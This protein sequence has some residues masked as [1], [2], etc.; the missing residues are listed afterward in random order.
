V[1]VKVL[2]LELRKGVD[3][4]R[5]T[6]HRLS[7]RISR[8]KAV[9]TAEERRIWEL[10]RI[11]PWSRSIYDTRNVRNGLDNWR[12]YSMAVAV[13]VRA[14]AVADVPGWE[15]TPARGPTIVNMLEEKL[16]MKE[17]REWTARP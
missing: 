8:C 6:L 1:T 10:G 2:V 3:W 7:G 14:A 9:L 11:V 15:A 4:E 12:T 13:R 17:E 5:R 16:F